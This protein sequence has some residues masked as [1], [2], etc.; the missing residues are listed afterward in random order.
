M[1]QSLSQNTLQ[2]V[3]TLERRQLRQIRCVYT[4][5]NVNITPSH[6]LTNPAEHWNFFTEGH[7]ERSIEGTL[8]AATGSSVHSF[9][10]VERPIARQTN[11][12]KCS[13]DEALLSPNNLFVVADNPLSESI[14]PA[15]L[16][17]RHAMKVQNVL[18]STLPLK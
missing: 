4:S 16:A 15:A 9:V 11:V 8:A 13:Q 7:C 5:Q 3:P 12:G 10:F 18:H 1:K 6:L 2:S 17:H 14:F